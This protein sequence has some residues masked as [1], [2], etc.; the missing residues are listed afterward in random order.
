MKL[1]N[2]TIYI[3]IIG[4]VILAAFAIGATYTQVFALSIFAT[5]LAFLRIDRKIVNFKRSIR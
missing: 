3:A 5:V 2:A 1:L 4:L